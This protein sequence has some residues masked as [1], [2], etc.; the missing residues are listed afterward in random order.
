MSKHSCSFI[1]YDIDVKFIFHIESYLLKII[2]AIH[3]K[4][5]FFFYHFY[6]PHFCSVFLCGCHGNNGLVDE[7]WLSLV[8]EFMNELFHVIGEVSA[9]G[10]HLGCLIKSPYRTYAD[11]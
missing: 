8:N 3:L 10:R 2:N 7:A 5:S 6:S 4:H 1:G 11:I 9:H